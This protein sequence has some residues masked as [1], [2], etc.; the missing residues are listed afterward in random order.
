M[1]PY[2]HIRIKIYDGGFCLKNFNRK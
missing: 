1:N 2:H